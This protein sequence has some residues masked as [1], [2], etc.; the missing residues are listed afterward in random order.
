MQWNIVKVKVKS[1]SRVWLFAT[2]WTVAHQ[3]PLS[4]RF[5]RQEYWSGLP[6]PSPGN[7]PDAG[8]EPGSPGFRQTVSLSESS[9][10]SYSAIKKEWNNVIF[11]DMDWSRVCHTEWSKS[12]R[13]GQ[14]SYDIAYMWNLIN[15]Y[16]CNYL[17]KRNRVIDVEN[18]LKITKG[19]GRER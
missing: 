16:K 9:G 13:K 8:I 14:I 11:N 10:K 6:F 2:P 3:A 1:L 15:W 19:K 12:D 4:M 18:K 7:L 5:S 17:Q